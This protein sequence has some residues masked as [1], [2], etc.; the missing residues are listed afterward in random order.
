MSEPVK[1]LGVNGSPRRYGGTYKLLRIALKAAERAGA[2]VKLVNLYDYEIKPCQACLCDDQVACR[3]PCPID[4]DF[5]KILEQVMWADALIIATPVYWYSPSGVV[6]NFID[7]L[8]CL[9]NMI[10]VTGRSLAEGKVAGFIAVGND[11]GTIL[12]ISQLMCILNSMGFHV[13]AWAL[14]YHHS[15]Q[16]VLENSS[17]VMDAANVGLILVKAAKLLREEKEW[18]NPDIEDWLKDV[19]EEVRREAEENRREQMK[20]REH[21]ANWYKKWHG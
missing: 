3:P 6:K 1:V 15:K 10:F 18:Y 16:D 11:S 20:S 19:V 14:A 5:P 4:D 17:A 9:E 21:L 7:R 12:C 8:T 2:E 13:P